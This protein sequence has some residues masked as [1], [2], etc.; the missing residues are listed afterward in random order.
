MLF[1]QLAD[2][3]GLFL[4]L[5]PSLGRHDADSLFQSV[6][7][8]NQIFAHYGFV[9]ERFEVAVR[10][11]RFDQL[12]YLLVVRPVQI[13]VPAFLARLHDGADDVR[14]SSRYFSAVKRT[15]P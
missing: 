13:I 2:F 5:G 6:S 12:V 4:K 7:G 3:E 15:L 11:I 10:V 14:V 1:L 8:N 9:V